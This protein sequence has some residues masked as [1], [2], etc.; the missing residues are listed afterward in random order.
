VKGFCGHGNEPSVFLKCWEFKSSC[1]TGGFSGSAQLHGSFFFFLGRSETESTVTEATTGL[2]YQPRVMDDECGTVGG[3][4]ARGNRSTRRKPAQVPLCPP[5]IP[6]D[7][8][9]ART[10]AKTVECRRLTA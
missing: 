7:L 5:Q 10:Q 8:A 9:R 1:T 4:A 6:Y 3:M 2:L